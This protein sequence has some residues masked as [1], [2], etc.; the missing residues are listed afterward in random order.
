MRRY[1]FNFAMGWMALISVFVGAN[2][3]VDPYRVFHEPWVREN[4]YSMDGGMRQ[5]ASGIINTETFD[6]I[7]LGTSMA[8][9]FSGNEAT[10]VFRHRFVNISL[11]GSKI[12]ERNVVLLYALRQK[13][14][15][16][17]IFSLDG[18]G[19]DSVRGTPMEP[20][21]YLYDHSRINDLQIYASSLKP[22]RYAFCR[23]T[24]IASDF[25][26]KNEHKDLENLVE[27]HSDL[28]HSRRFGGLNK[29]LEAKNNGQIKEALKSIAFNVRNIETGNV[30]PASPALVERNIARDRK[31]FNESL[32]TIARQYPQTRFYLF[33]PPYSRL[34]YAT[35]KQSDPQRFEEYLGILRSVIRESEKHPNV[36]IFGFEAEDFLDDIANYK[37]TSHYH[38]R[39]NS[40]ILRWMKNGE[41]E[42]TSSNLEPYIQEITERA[43]N[44]PLREIGSQIDAY[45][46]DKH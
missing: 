18:F 32:L 33:F 12:S 25:F 1:L 23:N 5:A 16:E 46:A 30:K 13:P 39:I 19:I 37:D 6:S 7:I 36:K 8:E 40:E 28:E 44:Y 29:W 41:H 20:Y 42:L 34:N 21:I 45:L 22:F 35:L 27:W 14:I 31:V 38:Q 4:Y 15:R 11:S 3:L 24:L 2:W 43:A 10:E 26:C 17:V 9:N